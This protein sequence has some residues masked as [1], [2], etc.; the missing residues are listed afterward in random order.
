VVAE[1]RGGL[2]EDMYAGMGGQILWRPEMS[3]FAF[4][5]DLY[6]VWQRNYDRMF[7]LRSYEV[8]TGHISAYY[9]SPYH[10]LTFAVHAGRYLAGDRGATFE[11]LRDFSTGVRLG[12]WATFTNVP[13]AKF[14]EGSF[15]KGII[16]HIPLQ[17]GLPIWSQSSYD[18]HLSPL[19]RDGGQRLN[20]DDSL[21]ESTRA[22]GYDEYSEH[23]DDLVNP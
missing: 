21:Y 14:G 22:I 6:Q 13:F 19:T 16:L 15:D 8:M 4:G 5:A 7:G 9:N 2:L 20:S 1:V 11:I 10:D 17:W 12:V 3:R 18:L 23:I